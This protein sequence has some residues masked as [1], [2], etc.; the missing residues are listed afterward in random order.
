MTPISFMRS[1]GL[2]RRRLICRLALRFPVFVRWLHTP[3]PFLMRRHEYTGPSPAHDL[4]VFLPGIEDCAEDFE[5]YG[6][7]DPV[8][9][10]EWPVDMVMVDAH[11]GYYADR[12]ILEELHE[13]VFRPAK[14]CGYRRIWIGGI[15]LG[16]FGALLYASRYPED[17]TGVLAMAPFLGRPHL[18]E[19]IAGAGGLARWTEKEAERED[20]PRQLWQWLRRSVMEPSKPQLYLAFGEQ[21]IFVPAQRLLAASLPEQ[22]VF[23]EPGTHNWPTWRRLWERF[24]RDAAPGVLQE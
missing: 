9:T 21:D 6:F 11:Y 4:F 8:R 10:M 2:F 3:R 7:V 15:S 5:R 17:I 12:T 14:A 24:L 22:Q 13:E 20:Y 16:G 1:I 18:I 23:I 19:E